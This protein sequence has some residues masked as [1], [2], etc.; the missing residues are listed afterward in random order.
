M[1]AM[2]AT[3]Y[4]SVM[5][6][7]AETAETAAGDEGDG[8][9]GGN[10]SASDRRE[11]EGQG[12]QGGQ[13][14]PDGLD[15]KDGVVPVIDFY[16][17]SIAGSNYYGYGSTVTLN[18]CNFLKNYTAGSSGGAEY[19]EG[20]ATAAMNN[21]T[22]SENSASGGGGGAQFFGWTL[23]NN[24]DINDCTYNKN[25]AGW[26]GGAVFV[27]QDVNLTVTDSIFADNV[28]SGQS[29]YGGG[30]RWDNHNYHNKTASITDSHFTNNTAG[31][32]GGLYWYD[33]YANTTT[34]TNCVFTENYADHGGGL[35][36]S[37]GEPNIIGCIFKRNHA[38]GRWAWLDDWTY[39]DFFGGGGGIFSFTSSGT[40]KDCTIT[41]NTTSG[42]GGGIYLGGGDMAPKLHNCLIT[43]NSAVLDG[44]GIASYWFA[45]PQITNCTIAG[46][47][48]SDP[49]NSN[50]GRGGGISCSYQS[51]T[52]MKDC[53]LADNA[54]THGNQIA[55]GNDSDPVYLQRP[56]ELNVSYSDIKNWHD[57]NQIYIF[58]GRILNIDANTVKDDDPCFVLGFYLS[59]VEAGQDY[60][61]PCFDIGSNTAAYYGLDTYTTRTD[62]VKDTNTVD[63]GYH[64]ALKRLTLVV[65]GHGTVT[66]DP[67][68]HDPN[69]STYFGSIFTLIATPDAG[70]RVK[71]WT[72]ADNT[73][74]WNIN[75]NTVTMTANKTVTV[76][77]EVEY[78]KTINVFGDVPGIKA[79]IDQAQNGDTIQIHS[80]TY[81]GTGFRIERKNI[82]I[83]GD[84]THPETVVID[85]AGES[86]GNSRRGFVLV[87]DNQYSVTLN[88][89]SIINSNTYM[90]SPFPPENPGDD[91]VP[92]KVGHNTYDDRGYYG[93]AII[94][95][96]NHTVKNCIIRDCVLTVNP[97]TNGNPGGDPNDE[98]TPTGH[99]KGGDGGYGGNAG[100]AGIFV[101]WGNA[102][103][104]NVTIE[105]CRAF[106][107]NAGNGATGYEDMLDNYP[108][109]ASGRGGDGGNVFGTGIY[110]RSGSP[111][112]ENV[113]V[114]NCIARAGKGGNGA[115]GA[116]AFHGGN[117]GL[118]GRV[119]GAGIYCSVNSA[120]TFVNCIV[121]NCRAYGGRGGNGGNGGQWVEHY[122]D[123]KGGYGGLTTEAGAGQGDIRM[124]SSNG[125][126]VFC[127]N[128]SRATFTDCAFIGNMTY[129][130]ISG[131]GGLWF[132]GAWRQQP[133]QNFRV[134][135]FG[136][137]V[138]CSTYS[139]G[140]FDGCQFRENRTAYNQDY[141]DPNYINDANIGLI[142]DYDGDL[143]GCG[144]GLCLWQTNTT[145]I[146]D[147][148]F[149]TNAAPVGGGIYSLESEM[150]ISDCNVFNNISYSGG[151]ILAVDSMA[152][153]TK[154]IISQN[155]AGTQPGAAQDTGQVV[156]GTGGGIYSLSTVLNITDTTITE[157]YAKLTAGGICLDGDIPFIDRPTIKNCLITNNRASEAGG[158]IAAIYF[159]EPLI[160]NCTIAENYVTDTNGHG[161]GLYSSYGSDTQVKDTI[162]W[163][164]NSVSGS[165]IA[166]SNG[167]PFIDMPAELTIRHSDID[168]LTGYAPIYTEADCTIDGLK[169]NGTWNISPGSG[170]KAENPFFVLGYYLSHI[171]AGQDYNSPCIDA[172]ST[173][174]ASLD[175]DTY[176]TRSD[177]ILD[178]GI[179]DMGF[180]HQ[181]AVQ[182]HN[183]VVQNYNITVKILPDANYPGIHGRITAEPNNLIS[184]NP[185]TATYTYKFYVGSSPT[186]TAVPDANYYV[187]G[188][189]DETNARISVAN[190][191]T[192]TVD[193][194]NTYFVRFKPGRT[195]QVSGGGTTL[196]NAVEMAENGDILIVA[197][198]TYSR[199]YQYRRQTD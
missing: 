18:D 145:T 36:W 50:H 129:G 122:P 108:A 84:P 73:P 21:C 74:Y 32:G 130:S 187:K 6:E 92:T 103:I 189:Y 195:I 133:R 8:G 142:T 106:A 182:D 60:N 120:P 163:L 174:A 109:G 146:T 71:S 181:A 1:L 67:N 94:I 62:G 171:L 147:C 196:R 128:W 167:G 156:F 168:L 10:G 81:V 25:T 56:A 70:Y 89:L 12:G 148:N 61:S 86:P 132:P 186:L 190:S 100:G 28:A 27:G 101:Q 29:A 164:N 95:Q 58:S 149:I 43:N 93:G 33:D 161:G 88:G 110:V 72:G 115:V 41:D 123:T 194:N 140:T 116:I 184:Y 15:G 65:I 76:E 19:Y 143:I 188:W 136:A 78:N 117:G 99:H 30:I 2:P 119:K 172:G 64:Y 126:A 102:R 90:L 162:I 155:I 97:A 134:P 191:L 114:R 57:A 180:H 4:T 17:S 51:K 177:G 165:Q 193:S 166:L 9:N 107:G 104:I 91:G 138:F 113:A 77:F 48:A 121:E 111:Y 151:G 153:I 14:N 179:V 55:I 66:V 59:N 154:S 185:T 178:A 35:Y 141:N 160:Q 75:T 105:N 199:R 125:G 198:G 13:G 31:F 127:D 87:G 42:S 175:L 69:S 170:N 83:L 44:G 24:I 52:I 79:A 98:G 85:C 118:P 139:S 68:N 169:L 26:D 173:T 20:R 38:N 22:F 5:A 197:A 49:A 135:S 150:L 183:I 34:I 124:Y 46:N 37:R 23:S 40:I 157:N 16:M 54:A 39:G 63:M 158:G 3:A 159:A 176:T 11:K 152:D 192:F 82:T 96:G 144:G 47:T 137:G 80:G 45:L 53:I 131:I 7:T 112:F